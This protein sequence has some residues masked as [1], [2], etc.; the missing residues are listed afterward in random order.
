M[1]SS[2]VVFFVFRVSMVHVVLWALVVL[3]G[4]VL[5]IGMGE[6][7]YGLT[8]LM[9]LGVNV[10]KGGIWVIGVGFLVGSTND[11]WRYWMSLVSF[12]SIIA[13]VIGFV[14]VEFSVV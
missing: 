6:L 8:C 13:I 10:V 14:I 1:V 12:W 4:L 9:G 2:W 11:G 7:F 3:V 5:V